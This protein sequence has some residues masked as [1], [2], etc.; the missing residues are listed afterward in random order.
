MCIRDSPAG[1]RGPGRGPQVPARPRGL[2]EEAPLALLRRVR[3]LG[4]PLFQGQLCVDGGTGAGGGGPVPEGGGPR[5]DA[6][7]ADRGGG[8]RVRQRE[9]LHRSPR[10]AGQG[11]SVPPGPP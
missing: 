9:P 5:H 11:G 1:G 10:G 7:A 2:P 8:A 3:V 4:R 6:Q